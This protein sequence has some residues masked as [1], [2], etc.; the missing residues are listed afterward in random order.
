LYAEGGEKTTLYL[1]W[2]EGCPHCSK[3]KE[4]LKRLRKQ[5]PQLNV[6]AFEVW[7]DPENARMFSGILEAAGIKSAG[8]PVTVV[9][10]RMW[11]G[12]SVHTGAQIEQEVALCIR[13][14][15]SD[16]VRSLTGEEDRHDGPFAV[17]MPFFGEL[18]GTTISLPVFTVTLGIMDS[19]NPCAFFVLFFLLGL[20][21]HARSRRRML[22]IGGTFVFFSGLVY[23][24]FMAAWLNV[25]MLVGQLTVITAVAGAVA[26]VVASINIK[27]FFL[28]KKGV[29]LSISDSARKR[30]FER[31]RNLLKATSVPSALAGTAVL[32]LAAN[33][34][35]LLCTAGFPMVYTRVL[36]LHELSTPA[37]YGYLAL[38]NAVYVLPLMAIV[39]AFVFT[40]GAKKLSEWQGRKLKLVSGMMMLLLGLAL[41]LHPEVL[42][43]I[44]ATAGML[45]AA[46]AVSWFIITFSKRLRPGLAKG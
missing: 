28:F 16:T 37:Y 7:H 38:Y 25:F 40:L 6:R 12:F 39:A 29:S 4:F 34:Y 17:N 1:F 10:D 2:G 43:N 26:L 21:V 22:L 14:G 35:E 24:V 18:N 23:F 9:G 13:D 45:A 8:V 27:D 15:C 19:F 20:L 11:M 3:E 46:L 42:N 31:M 5:Y 30:L 41:L 44:V 32:A 36:T 33:T